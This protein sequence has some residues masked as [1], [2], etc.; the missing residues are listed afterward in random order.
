[1]KFSNTIELPDIERQPKKSK[2]DTEKLLPKILDGNFFSV[3][4]R[5]E[6]GKVETVCNQCG[7]IRKGSVTSTGN[8]IS[9]YRTSHSEQMKDLEA[10]LK[11]SPQSNEADNN[12]RPP[13][14]TLLTDINPSASPDEL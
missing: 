6:D 11:G 2:H 5:T 4:K 12:K 10:Y 8:F 3:T 1:M 7:K 13:R 9:H 14:Q